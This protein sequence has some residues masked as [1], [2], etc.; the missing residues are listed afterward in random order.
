MKPIVVLTDYEPGHRFRLATFEALRHASD[1]TGRPTP[2]SEVGT[3]GIGDPGALVAEAAAIVVGPGS[4][5]RDPEAVLS[6]I[7]QARER[8]VPLVGT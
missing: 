4:P 8:E 7:R 5:Y 2:I 1:F 3:D 6:L